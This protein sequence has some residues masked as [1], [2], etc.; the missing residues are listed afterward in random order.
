MNVFSYLVAKIVPTRPPVSH[1]DRAMPAALIPPEVLSDAV[2]R[3]QSAWQR[4]WESVFAPAEDA[5]GKAEEASDQDEPT[6]PIAWA[7]RETKR[8]EKDYTDEW[9]AVAILAYLASIGLEPRDT[10]RR[11]IEIA[12]ANAAKETLLP[13]HEQ[14]ER[15]IVEIETAVAAQPNLVPQMDTAVRVLHRVATFHDPTADAGKS[16]TV[17]VDEALAQVAREMPPAKAFAELHQSMGFQIRRLVRQVNANS[18]S[19]EEWR[20]G[21]KS[22]FADNYREAFRLGKLMNGGE[23]VLTGTDQ[24]RLKALI[25]DENKFLARWLKD[26]RTKYLDLPDQTRAARMLWRGELYADALKGVFNEG[27]LSV[28]PDLEEILWQT[29][30]A[31]SCPTCIDENAMGWRAASTLTRVPGDGSTICTTNCMCFLTRRSARNAEQTSEVAKF[32]PYHDPSN[33]QFATGPGGAGGIGVKS[34]AAYSIEGDG[35]SEAVKETVGA[36]SINEGRKT[37]TSTT[38]KLTEKESDALAD[39]QIAGFKEIN[40]SLRR[41]DIK[42]GTKNKIESLDRAIAKSTLSDDVVVFRG[43]N[44]KALGG[45]PKIGDVFEAKGFVSTTRDVGYAVLHAGSRT[46]DAGAFVVAMRLSKGTHGFDLNTIHDRGESE[47]L[48]PR[49][50]GFRIKGMGMLHKAASEGYNAVHQPFIEVEVEQ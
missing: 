13:L 35:F 3:L 5:V 40:G 34:S 49:G 6:S 48:L 4:I 26:A 21:M 45:T 15:A 10:E 14:I 36:V 2:Q 22:I 32:N 50:A 42:A 47:V 30:A 24:A 12:A 37:Y 29:T 18:I 17:F 38:E 28:V 16:I 7:R 25:T 20:A 39:Y 31:E 43:M 9:I 19:Q 41:N 44:S 1:M 8:A 46:G 11:A 33:G 23:Y 27:W